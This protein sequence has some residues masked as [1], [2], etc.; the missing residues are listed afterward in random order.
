MFVIFSIFYILVA[1]GMT[2]LILMQRGQGANAGASFGG[3]SSGTVFGARGSASF[4]S[5]ATAGL[6]VVFIIMSLGMAIY[7]SHSGAPTPSNDLGVMAGVST[8]SSQ[9]T[10]DKAKVP[11]QPATEIPQATQPAGATSPTAIPAGA[12]ATDGANAGAVPTA[13][14]AAK[15]NAGS[16]ADNDKGSPGSS[17]N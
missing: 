11:A 14:P 3:G 8:T 4:M 10:N 16:A 13:T 2:A 5:R 15:D 12:N 1:A 17:K 6:F 9:T 7:L